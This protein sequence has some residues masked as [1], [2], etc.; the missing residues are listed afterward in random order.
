MNNRIMVTVEMPK[1]LKEK[2]EN[3]SKDKEMSV[4]ALIRWII[5]EWL[6]NNSL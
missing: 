1:E 2:L 4:S 3:I 5:K 6:K